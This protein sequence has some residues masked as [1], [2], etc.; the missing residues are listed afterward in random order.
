MNR[1]EVRQRQGDIDGAKQ[2]Y[3]Q[4]LVVNPVSATAHFNR[5]QHCLLKEQW[6]EG[7]AGYGW[8]W[9]SEHFDSKKRDHGLPV[10]DGALEDNLTLLIW[11]EQ[12][13]G[14]QILFASLLDELVARSLSFVVEIDPRLVPLL[15][16]GRTGFTVYGYDRVPEEVLSRCQSQLPIGSLGAFLRSKPEDFPG[17]S[18]FIEADAE[19]IAILK[20]TYQVKANGRPIVGVAW[21]SANPTFGEDKSLSLEAWAPIL[22]TGDAQ[23]VSLQHGDVKTDVEAACNAFGVEIMI[24]GDIDPMTDVDLA[25]AQI[26]AMDLV[27]TTSNT[28]AHLSGAL[29]QE[30]WVMVHKVPEWRWGLERTDSLWYPNVRLFRQTVA[31]D[32]SG[33]VT[34]VASALRE[35]LAS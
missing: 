28:V 3:D 19:R 29:G 6:T 20:Q 9:Q 17:N 35:K 15:Q 30:T 22:K 8:R 5:G 32:W 1:G 23:F 2:D 33:P 31:Q 27:I 34:D 16:R 14:D 21:H 7:W 13:I 18:A 11:G 10:W 24:Y 12:G 26:A 4:A 25:A